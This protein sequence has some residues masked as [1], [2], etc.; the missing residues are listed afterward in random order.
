MRRR[1]YHLILPTAVLG[2]ALV[3]TGSVDASKA[4]SQA[5]V[6]YQVTASRV[7]RLCVGTEGSFEVGVD[8][9]VVS[10]LTPALEQHSAPQPQRDVVIE[11]TPEDPNIAGLGDNVQIVGLDGS[12]PPV[13]A[14]TVHGLKDGKTSIKLHAKIAAMAETDRWQG[15]TRDQFLSVDVVVTN[16]RFRLDTVSLWKIPG[17]ANI[18]IGATIT[19]AV[20]EPN[21]EGSL[22]QLAHVTWYFAASQV[23]DC[24][25]TITADSI[26]AAIFASIDGTGQLNVEVKFDPVTVLD[27]V[28]C[29]V[30]GTMTIV[31]QPEPLV[32]SVSTKGGGNTQ[33]HALSGQAGNTHWWVQPLDG[34]Q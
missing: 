13:A 21:A 30:G 5:T 15:D 23:G 27:K 16:C 17:E 28:N 29:G 19:D 32:F 4:P 2:P 11:A 1:W 10:P 14:F 22:N 25:A 34:S 12:Q 7:P 26:D 9:L 18:Q 3:V 33:P 8:R 24:T 31:Q 20:L 6:T